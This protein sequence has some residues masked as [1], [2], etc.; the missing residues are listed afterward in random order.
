MTTYSTPH[1]LSQRG[2]TRAT[3]YGFSN[4]SIAL[5][6][7]LH[8]VWL[9]AIAKVCGRTYDYGTG[10]WGATYQLFEGCDNHTSPALTADSNGNVRMV[11]GPHG[12]WGKWNQGCF[13]WVIAESPGQ[14]EKWTGEQSFGYNATYASLLH[15]TAGLDVIVYRGGEKPTSL[16]FQKQ[17]PQ[18]GWS[19]AACLLEQE[20]EPQ[21]TNYG[22]IIACDSRGALYTACHF[23]NIGGSDN[24]AVGGDASRKRSYGVAVLKSVDMGRTWTDLSGEHFNTPGLYDERIAAPPAHA[25]V[26]LKGL[27]VDSHDRIWVLTLKPGVDDERILL[28]LWTEHGWHTTDLQPCLPDDRVAVD[29]AMTIDTRDRI[30]LA[31][32]AVQKGKSDVPS[33]WGCPTSEVFHL[34]TQGTVQDSECNMISTPDV[35][36]ANWLP[37]IS[38]SGPFHPVN[39]PAILYTHGIAGV[40]CSPTTETDVFCVVAEMQEM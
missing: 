31:M 32:T 26:Y 16:M 5:N 13:K 38:M 12:R 11:Y 20:I 6:G 4:K 14:I 8:V 27:C 29:A 15:T 2:S 25:N 33:A 7:K 39:N 22:G 18:G 36:T 40:G 34:V 23:Y 1:L 10:E 19:T 35:Q 24:R 21:Y 17:R 30:H 28:S 37:N 9:D 3:A